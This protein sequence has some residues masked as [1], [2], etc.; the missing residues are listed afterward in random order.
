DMTRMFKY[1]IAFNQPLDDWDVSQVKYMD[2][3]F[4]MTHA[5]LYQTT[6]AVTQASNSNT[7]HFNQPLGNWNLNSLNSATSM[8]YLCPLSCEN[9]SLTLQSWAG[10]PNTSTNVHLGAIGLKYSPDVADSRAYLV[11]GLGW[12]INDA[13][14]GTCSL[15][16]E[17]Q[18]FISVKIY[19]NPTT[20]ILN[21]EYKQ[22]LKSYVLYDLSGRQV[23]AGRLQQ[24]QINMAGL[25][26]GD[27][28]LNRKA[29]IGSRELIE[30]VK[31]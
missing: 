9:Y 19:P 20:G 23:K 3:M 16:V 17:K 7:A 21:V 13:G 24:A 4:D 8:F 15:G 10:N 14:Q 11:N 27:Y 1:A 12:S 26:N 25:E 31:K 6:Q 22:P 30:G 29:E 28:F 18:G 5:I 2:H